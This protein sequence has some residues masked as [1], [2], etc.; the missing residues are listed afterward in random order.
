MADHD[1]G[2]RGARHGSQERSRCRPDTR[3]WS[4]TRHQLIAG[5]DCHHLSCAIVPHVST[6]AYHLASIQYDP[7]LPS[8][9]F[10]PTRSQAASPVVYPEYGQSALGA[11]PRLDRVSRFDPTGY[12]IVRRGRQSLGY[13]RWIRDASVQRSWGTRVGS[14]LQFPT[15]ITSG[16][17]ADGIV[18]GID[19][20][21]SEG[22]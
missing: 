9:F 19:R 13:G 6:Y 22:L 8:P 3:G 11:H 20:L 1:H 14:L 5:Y 18:H 10:P 4:M 2:R 15:S 12:R 17:G 16:E 21:A 7:I